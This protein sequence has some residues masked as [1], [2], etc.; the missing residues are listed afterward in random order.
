M[1][2]R[3]ALQENRS[4]IL[5]GSGNGQVSFGPSVYGETWNIQILGVRVSS[6]VNEPVA[7]VHLGAPTDLNFIGG[8]YSGSQDADTSLNVTL[9]QGQLLY[10]VWMGGD[11][12]ATATAVAVGERIV[13]R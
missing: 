6:A 8:S 2:Q 4:V 3:L 10:V 11:A 13:N 9:L 5:D 1:T 12:G 7:R